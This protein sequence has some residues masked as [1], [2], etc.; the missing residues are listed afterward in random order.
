LSSNHRVSPWCT[1]ALDFIESPVVN[2]NSQGFNVSL[3]MH[4]VVRNL[5]WQNMLRQQKTVTFFSR[6]RF[7]AF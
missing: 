1:Q 5:L 2:I 3:A 4:H 6:E 7:S